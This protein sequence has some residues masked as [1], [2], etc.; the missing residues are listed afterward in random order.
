M[1]EV[2]PPGRATLRPLLEA[3]SVAIVGASTRPGSFGNALVRRVLD[4]GFGGSVHPVNPRYRQVEGL[5]CVP[6]LAGLTQPAELALLAVGPDRVEAQL[7]A[8]ADAGTPA[9]VVYTGLPGVGA[10]AGLPGGGLDARLRAVASAAGMVVC[11]ANCMGFLN[12]ERSLRACAY[13]QPPDLRPGSVTFI[14]HSGSA[15][16]ALLHTRRGVRFNLVVSAGTEFSVTMDGYLDYALDLP[17]TRAIGLFMET[18]RNPAGLLRALRRAA[19]R[20]VPVVCLKVGRDVRSRRF[21]AT[22]T[23]AMAG[24]DAAYDAVFDAHG[25]LRVADLDEMMDT[26]E[27]LTAARRPGPGGLAAVTDSGGERALLA[28]AAADIGVPFARVGDETLGRLRGM[29][30]PALVPDNPLDAWDALEGAEQVFTDSL[31]TLHDDA[32]VAAVALAVDLTA[33]EFSDVGYV[34]VAA[35]VQAATTKPFL[36]LSHVSSAVGPRDAQRLR[37]AGVP[38]LEGTRTGLAAVRNMFAL[39]DW[40]A[41]PPAERPDVAAEVTRRWRRRLADPAP[42]AVSESFRLLADYGIPVAPTLP[43]AGPREAIAAAERIGW[44]VVLKTAAAGVTHKSEAGGVRLGIAGPDMMAAAYAVMSRSLGP[45]VTVSATACPGAELALGIARDPQFGPLVMAGAGGVLVE[46]I[47]DRVFGVPPLDMY[48]ARAL[49]DRLKARRLLDGFRGAPASDVTAVASAIVRLSALAADVGDLI[50][51]LDIN[52]LIAGPSGCVAV[53]V[54]IARDHPRL[55]CTCVK[56][57]RRRAANPRRHRGEAS[58][59]RR[60]RH[61]RRWHAANPGGRPSHG[62]AQVGRRQHHAAYRAGAGPG[63]RYQPQHRLAAAAHSRASRPGRPR[64]GNAAVHGRV[65]RHV[66]RLGGNRRRARP[67]GPSAAGSPGRPHRR[68]GHAGG[69]QAVQPRLR[70][71]GRPAEHHG[72]ELAAQAASAARHLRRQG[73]PGLAAARRKGRDPAQGPA[74][75]HTP[76]GYRPRAAGTGARCGPPGRLRA[77]RPRVR[78]VLLGCLGRGAE[79]AELSHRG[80]Q[81]LGAGAQEPGQAAPRDRA[82]SRQD[83]RRGPQPAGLNDRG[84]GSRPA[85]P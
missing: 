71:S 46:L 70:R 13:A 35:Q 22:H 15:F 65:R 18:S 80:A 8:A 54:L 7:R 19:E 26:L 42:L 84:H 57:G 76:Y 60:R 67:Q 55:C 52:P 62:A 85:C 27:L 6:S 63:V 79:R 59:R 49:L 75:V 12:L 56:P 40:C 41:R 32:G 4:G 9:A 14:S 23:G 25:V 68:V 82:G 21:V 20:D 31:I 53:D 16:S 2:V 1:S 34:G 47:A 81:R 72:S 17:S 11:G 64:P 10:G 44:P 36:V 29:L 78:G 51:G 43:A 45:D 48:R 83:R 39:R 30:P 28:D 66:G 74:A 69:G 73:L 3:R 38:V 33:E 61:R 5:G 37:D 58:R 50:R 24:Q 77:L